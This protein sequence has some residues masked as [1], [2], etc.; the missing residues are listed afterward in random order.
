V[1]FLAGGFLALAGSGEMSETMVEV[2]KDLIS[3]SE[4]KGK[5]LFLDTPAGFQENADLLSHRAVLYFRDKVQNN[6]EI[7]S[8]KSSSIAKTDQAEQV[9]RQIND[10]SYLLMGPGSPTYAVAQ[11]RETPIPALLTSMIARGGSLMASSAAALTV[12]RHTLPVYEIYKVGAPL[13]WVEGTN[14][15]GSLGLELTV[16]PHWNNAEGGNHDTRYCYMG[17]KRM[18]LLEKLLP[19]DS[20]ILGIDEHTAI[21]LDFAIQE[22]VI[23]G[24][25]SVTIRKNGHEKRFRRGEI[26]TFDYLTGITKVTSQPLKPV[27]EEHETDVEIKCL[28][29]TSFWGLLHRIQSEFQSALDSKDV[30]SIITKLLEVDSLLW[31]TQ[32][33]LENPEFISQGRELFREMIVRAGTAIKN[34]RIDLPERFRALVNEIIALREECRIQEKW[35]EADLLREILLKSGIMLSDTNDGTIWNF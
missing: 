26:V 8:F 19:L 34:E 17:E 25:G 27:S 30:I 21:I 12:G 4:P 24:I 9:Y 15:L 31:E 22:A 35:A 10:A 32:Q 3:R 2:H 33:D 18:H 11:L 14:I 29:D 7:A 5:V 1:I 13:H 6:M 28:E 20:I 16:I 23:K